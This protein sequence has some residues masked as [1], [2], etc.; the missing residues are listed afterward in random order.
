MYIDNLR[1]IVKKS[2]F[3][4]L[5]TMFILNCMKVDS[6]IYDMLSL[7]SRLGTFA[8]FGS[9]WDKSFINIYILDWM[10]KYLLIHGCRTK[11]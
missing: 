8:W 2:N 7:V 6:N 4:K 10:S 1:E 11:A 5:V 9:Q 3:M